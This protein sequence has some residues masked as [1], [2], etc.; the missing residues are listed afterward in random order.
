MSG[1]DLYPIPY[2][3]GQEQLWVG[4]GLAKREVDDRQF[5]HPLAE[6]AEAY[7]TYSLGD[8]AGLRLPGGTTISLVEL[9]VEARRPQWNVIVGSLWFDRASAQLARRSRST[10]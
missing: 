3:P 6:G 7:Y 2:Y 10:S 1:A 9:R 4:S 5:V 8:S